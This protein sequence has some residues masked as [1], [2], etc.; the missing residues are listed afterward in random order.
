MAERI[1]DDLA[2]AAHDVGA[3]PTVAAL[4]LPLNTA[5]VVR[6]PS[7]RAEEVLDFARRLV[8]E[9]FRLPPLEED[10]ER[11]LTGVIV[12]PAGAAGPRGDPAAPESH[13]EMVCP[14]MR[15]MARD[16]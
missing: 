14:A 11:L 13:A 1:A 12:S 3:G 4:A 15:K 10:V 16:S 5:V 2:D 9:A 6:L 8:A 7:E